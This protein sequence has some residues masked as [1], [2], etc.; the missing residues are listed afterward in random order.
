[1]AKRVKG[2]RTERTKA[3]LPASILTIPYYLGVEWKE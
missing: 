3:F 1:M 2:E